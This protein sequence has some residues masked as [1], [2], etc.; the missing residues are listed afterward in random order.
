MASPWSCIR[1][2]RVHTLTVEQ[3]GKI[4]TGAYDNWNQVGGADRKIVVSFA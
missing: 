4:F 3:I 1:R 2:I